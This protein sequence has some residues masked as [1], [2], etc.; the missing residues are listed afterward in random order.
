MQQA[1]HGEDPGGAVCT[2]TRATPIGD[3]C[4]CRHTPDYFTC[5]QARVR[6]A[7]SSTPLRTIRFP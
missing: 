5:M 4:E 7:L 3:T 2:R 6:R 1:P